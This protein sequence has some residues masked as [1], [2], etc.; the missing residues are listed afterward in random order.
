[1][2]RLV[3]PAVVGY[4]ALAGRWDPR[5][6][7]RRRRGGV[8]LRAPNEPFAALFGPDL[9]SERVLEAP[10]AIQLRPSQRHREQSFAV[11]S[12]RVPDGRARSTQILILRVRFI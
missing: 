10:N 9:V 11:V 4:Q 12:A 7:R 6:V 5:R 8:R 1:G 2:P 3:R